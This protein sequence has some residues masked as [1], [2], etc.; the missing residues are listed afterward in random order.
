MK[1]QNVEIE[2]VNGWDAHDFAD[3]YI[4][5]AEHEDGT[6]LTEDEL[7]DIPHEVVYEEIL[8]SL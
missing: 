7:D 3:A 1:I 6:P 2:N 8:K 4:T 5:Y